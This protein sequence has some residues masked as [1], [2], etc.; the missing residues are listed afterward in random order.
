MFGEDLAERVSKE[1]SPKSGCGLNLAK[2][3]FRE[4]LVFAVGQREAW[5]DQ[6]FEG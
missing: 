5:C 6:E 1:S 4:K 3:R 2:D